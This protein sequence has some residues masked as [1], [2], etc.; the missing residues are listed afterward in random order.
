MLT[1]ACKTCVESSGFSGGCPLTR[2]PQGAAVPASRTGSISAGG[3]AT[4]AAAGTMP[5]ST[6]S[7][8]DRLSRTQA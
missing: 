1:R 6:S 5:F 4:A 2:L 8:C 7:V 3:E